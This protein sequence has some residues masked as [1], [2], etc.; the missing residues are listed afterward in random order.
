MP[1]FLAVPSIIFI[2]FNK[3]CVLRSTI[4]ILAISSSSA[5]VIFP[6]L[7][8]F[9]VEDPF[10]A[11]MICFNKT[12]AGGVFNI[13]VKLLSSKIEISTGTTRSPLS[14]VFALYSLQNRPILIPCW[15]NAGPIGGAGVAFPAFKANL[16]TAT[17][18]F[19][20]II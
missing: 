3:S 15:P 1:I 17:I 8:L 19:P 16:T 6:T 2:A 5:L 13:N 7:V 11:F 9:G 14:E 20:I 4:F 10:L 12:E 18:V